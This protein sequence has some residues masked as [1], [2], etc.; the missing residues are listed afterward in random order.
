MKSIDLT[1]KVLG[2]LTV[3]EKSKNRHKHKNA[4]LWICRCE[5]GNTKEVKTEQLNG[6]VQSCGCAR[7]GK[8]GQGNLTQDVFIERSNSADNNLY[9]YSLVDFVDVHSKVKIRCDKHGVFEQA[10]RHHMVGRGCRKC[11]AAQV[12]KARSGSVEKF[13]KSAKE[14]HGDKFNYEKVEYVDCDTHVYITCN[15]CS[16]SFRQTPVSHLSGDGCAKCGSVAAGLALRSNTQEFV[17]KAR[18][19]HGDKYDYTKVEYKTVSTKVEIK[20][21][22]CDKHFSQLANSHLNGKGCPSCSHKLRGFSAEKDG[23]L[24]ILVSGNITKVGITNKAVELRAITIS[25]SYGEDFS[26]VKVYEMRGDACVDVEEMTLDKLRESYTSPTR[27]FDGYTECFYNVDHQHL[28][29]IIDG[30]L[31]ETVYD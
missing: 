19:I 18:A 23:F 10:P 24:Y 27:K 2:K 30:I 17:S 22:S 15:K 7:G 8:K 13:V 11:A 26:V 9:D 16:N 21:V 4:I 3:L 20:C 5:C 1:G 12:S 6:G 25:L 31:K 14:V 28:Y 29:C